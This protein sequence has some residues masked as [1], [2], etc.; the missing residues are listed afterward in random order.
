MYRYFCTRCATGSLWATLF[1]LAF[2]LNAAD[3][4]ANATGGVYYL[5]TPD[6]RSIPDSVLNN[7]NVDG[8]AYRA[9]WRALEPRDGVFNLS[10]IDNA[11]TLAASSGKRLSLM[12]Q[13]GHTT[14]SWVYF[15]GAATFH[16]I[17]DQN[18][19][20]ALCSNTKIPIPWDAIF[21]VKWA[22]LVQTLGQH[23][24]SN[25]T[26]AFVYLTGINGVSGET[27]LPANNGNNPIYDIKGSVLCT[28]NNDTWRWQT[29]GYT[30][31]RVESAWI[32]IVNYYAASFPAKR[33]IAPLVP[34]SF[35]PLDNYG[36]LLALATRY[37]YDTQVHRDVL[38][39]GVTNYRAHF[40]ARNAGLTDTY[41][42]KD[43]VDVSPYVPT[44]QQ[45]LS[46]LGARLPGA[47]DLAVTNHSDFLELYP[48]DIE[49]PRAQD[50]LEYVHGIL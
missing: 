35:P 13:A 33:W 20:P 18:H 22:K 12:V 14:P 25:P 15:D 46:A 38:S 43:I 39:I 27:S 16:F 47:V 37:S 41:I 42:M 7:P 44:G 9:T 48:D 23:Y 1:A 45:T 2:I 6:Q 4:S 28:S 49:D 21:Q 10:E 31:L 8:I 17:W 26:L 11:L 5:A 36:H 34:G 32:Q 40:G 19:G 29:L 50:T 30:R 24:D 3:V